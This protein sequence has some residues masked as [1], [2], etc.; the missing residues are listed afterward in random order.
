[1]CPK[2][3]GVSGAYL[4]D[5]LWPQHT[6]LTSRRFV[7]SGARAFEGTHLCWVAV[8]IFCMAGGARIEYFAVRERSQRRCTA[9]RHADQQRQGCSEPT[10]APFVCV[11]RPALGSQLLLVRHDT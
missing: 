9:G 8:D 3:V 7:S 11:T 10:P 6:Q 1:M 5:E 4:R 2:L